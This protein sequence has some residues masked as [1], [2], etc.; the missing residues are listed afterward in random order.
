MKSQ[1][2]IL[3]DAALSYLQAGLSVIP[4]NAQKRPIIPEWSPFQTA[5]PTDAQVKSWPWGDAFG[6]AI[7]GGQVSGNLEILDFDCD[8]ESLVPCQTIVNEES[9]G[10]F[11]KPY[12][13][14]SPHG[15]H[16]IYRCS[17]EV[18]LPGNTKLAMKLVEVP[19]PGEHPH[20]YKPDQNLKAY[21]HAGKLIISPDLIETRGSGGYCVVAPSRGG[22]RAG[23]GD[24]CD[25]P[26]LTRDEREVLI[27]AARSLN[28]VLP[29]FKPND[30]RRQTRSEGSGKLPGQDFD[31]RGDVRA[32]LQEAGWTFAGNDNKGFEGWR[33]PGKTKGRSASLIDG[34]IFYP[35]S[36]NS[37]PFEPGRAYGP[38]SVYA[39]LKHGGD[40]Q[41][42]ARALQAQGYGSR[43]RTSKDVAS[44][45]KEYL[46][47]EFDGGVFKLSDLKRELGLNDHE[48]TLARQCVKRLVE[49]GALQKHGHQMGSY[50]VVDRKKKPI[51]FEATEAGA[52]EIILPGRL[53]DIVTIRDGDMICIAGY[54]NQNKT[55][56]AVEIA[57]LNLEQFKIHFFV[58][59]YSA[60]MKRRLI[61]FGIDFKHPNFK[62][63]PIEK[64][65]YIP[66]KIEPGQGVLNIIDHYPNVDNF[67]LVGK[68]Q[69]E[70]HRALDGAICVITHQKL[71]EK[72]KDAIGG[73]FWTI[74]PTL[75]VT[76]FKEEGEEYRNQMHIRKG[77][78]PAAG[79]RDATGLNLRYK[80]I[81]GC[82]FEYDPRGWL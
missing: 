47:D 61:D 66:D 52:S 63:Y 8:G 76:L 24:L 12:F 6:V 69:D 18:T 37:H 77:K 57:R 82:R 26:V 70:I 55:A 30:G 60:R 27:A 58:T 14:Y 35:F 80:L 65:D 67:Y 41:E 71:H 36:S 68:V 3:L 5:L 31:E 51:D 13:E 32:L 74:T 43:N 2:R 81:R 21:Q 54:K 20:P 64:S 10:L 42:A 22:Y 9:A 29:A 16:L 44:R 4:V 23:C 73:S 33:R 59:E 11:A 25:L 34:K 46:F 56:L 79:R 17:P 7:I 40:F 72:D 75:A 53:Q 45:V 48:Y 62:A 1:G 28:E 15:G 38:F 78:E 19:G 39:L 49:S 50:R